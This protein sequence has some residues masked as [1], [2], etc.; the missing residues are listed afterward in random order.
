MPPPT[1]H[2]VSL[3]HWR[4]LVEVAVPT[5]PVAAS[6]TS[7]MPHGLRDSWIKQYLRW[8][9][10]RLESSKFF[11]HLAS[12][13]SQMLLDEIIELAHVLIC[14][15]LLNLGN[16]Y[17]A[18]RWT[19]QTSCTWWLI[20]GFQFKQITVD[21]ITWTLVNSSSPWSRL[22][23]TIYV[24]PFTKHIISHVSLRHIFHYSQVHVKSCI[25]MK[26]NQADLHQK[27]R[28]RKQFLHISP[29]KAYKTLK[30]LPLQNQTCFAS[31]G[32]CQGYALAS[33]FSTSISLFMAKPKQHVKSSTLGSPSKWPDIW[34]E[35]TRTSWSSS[36]YF[37]KV[38]S[39][40]FGQYLECL[41][42]NFGYFRNYSGY[43]GSSSGY[44]GN[45]SRYSRISFGYFRS[46]S[47]LLTNKKAY[48]SPNVY[49]IVL[50]A[51]APSFRAHPLQPDPAAWHAAPTV[52]Q[53][54][55]GH[56]PWL[57]S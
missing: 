1:R 42:A 55:Q 20:C 37:S 8:I 12:C 30:V 27:K 38:S 47:G 50:H 34:T 41:R 40:S 14:I 19:R 16:R 35:M 4:S 36:G 56:R 22:C 39:T 15:V 29:M 51:F 43:F 49:T 57:A 24:A 2:S 6:A 11:E 54:I 46:S 48:A 9:E 31:P 44:F 21:Y 7:P 23:R 33:S 5:T 53:G 18:L 45:N 52:L 13:G 26:L 10:M 3:P 25:A 32:E 28:E 17:S